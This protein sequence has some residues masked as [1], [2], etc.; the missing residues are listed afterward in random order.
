MV[1]IIMILT[2]QRLTTLLLLMI[3]L[4]MDEV[5]VKNVLSFACR[6]R[7]DDTLSKYIDKKEALDE[8]LEQSLVRGKRIITEKFNRDNID[9]ILD[10]IHHHFYHFHLFPHYRK[11]HYLCFLYYCKELHP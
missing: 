6:K 10:N 9:K 5:P 3:T 7:A 11:I 4:E 8:E 2:E 1:G